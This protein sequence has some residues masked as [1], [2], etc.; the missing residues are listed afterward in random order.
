M[1]EPS[2]PLDE[3]SFRTHTKSA[4]FVA[5]VDEAKWRIVGSIEWPIV[6]IAISAADR[7]GAPSEFFFR[8]D[9]S[10]YPAAPPTARLWNLETG[11]DLEQNLRPTGERVSNV[12]RIVWP[13]SPC[14]YAP[15]DRLAIAPGRHPEWKQQY[16]NRSWTPKRHLTWVLKY[17]HELL[18]DHDYA[19]IH[20]ST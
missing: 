17:L 20:Q 10:D 18:N 4:V 1:I 3:C 14:L 7:T 13:E 12:F 15:F 8:F 16:P 9:L 11:K 5:G 19:G 2:M 6:M